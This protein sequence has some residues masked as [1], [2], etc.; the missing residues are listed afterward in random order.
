MLLSTAQVRAHLSICKSHLIHKSFWHLTLEGGASVVVLPPLWLVTAMVCPG[1]WVYPVP[2]ASPQDQLC[3]LASAQAAVWEWP[4]RA[5]AAVLVLW[6][7]QDQFTGGSILMALSL[8]SGQG[9]RKPGKGRV[10]L[11][12]RPPTSAFCI[13]PLQLCLT[14]RPPRAGL[15]FSAE[16]CAAPAPHSRGHGEPS[17]AAWTPIR[18]G[19][20]TFRRFSR[21][22]S[23]V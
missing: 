5:A 3:N 1:C 6:G 2:G 8:I 18:D 14:C 9:E 21:E 22:D 17:T 15:A 16:T 7:G 19:H 4:V 20:M 12:V 23:R 13:S 11:G 10:T